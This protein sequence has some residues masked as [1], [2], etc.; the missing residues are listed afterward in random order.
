MKVKLILETNEIGQLFYQLAHVAFPENVF[1][2]V[3]FTL[4][5][6]QIYLDQTS[7]S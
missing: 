2:S 4:S 7:T 5:F 1:R 6:Y 3:S